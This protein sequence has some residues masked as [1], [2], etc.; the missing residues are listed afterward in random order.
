MRHGSLIH[1]VAEGAPPRCQ[2]LQLRRPARLGWPDAKGAAVCYAGQQARQHYAF[3]A[4]WVHL[5]AQRASR[6]PP[7]R[8]AER[9]RRH[10][11]RSRSCPEDAGACDAAHLGRAIMMY[12][13]GISGEQHAGQII[14]AMSAGKRMR[15]NW[16]LTV[17]VGLRVG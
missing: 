6:P 4:A 7:A 11:R 17:L 9:C 14:H 8:G 1:E 2:L 15:D 5:A 10:H 12:K 16:I 3:R 13:V